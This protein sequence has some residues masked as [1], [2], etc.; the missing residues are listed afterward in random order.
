MINSYPDVANPNKSV[1]VDREIAV[2]SLD[3]WRYY[4]DETSG[5]IFTFDIENSILK[6]EPDRVTTGNSYTNLLTRYRVMF[7]FSSI[8]F[9]IG[10]VNSAL[11]FLGY[12]FMDW[13]S[14]I[15]WIICSFG[16]I[17]TSAFL[18]IDAY[19]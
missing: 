6:Y 2:C 17:G 5:N 3:F 13:L 15:V 14:T 7:F 10:I 4:Q 18:A 1:Y 8:L 11:L 19:E 9:V 16:L 12:E